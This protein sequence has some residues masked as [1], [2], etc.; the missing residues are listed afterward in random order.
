ME[1]SFETQQSI[2]KTLKDEM[3]R[4]NHLYKSKQYQY[5]IELEKLQQICQHE[6]IRESD[7]DYH[8]PGF[9]YTCKKCDYFTRYTPNTFTL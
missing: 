4:L 1:E 5:K 8:K 9:Y 6:F 2:V 7:G 3:H